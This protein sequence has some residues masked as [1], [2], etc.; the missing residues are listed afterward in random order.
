MTLFVC[1]PTHTYTFMTHFHV[2][3]HTLIHLW[4]I[5]MSSYPYLYN[6]TLFACPP[7]YTYILIP[8]YN[9]LLIHKYVLH[10]THTYFTNTRSYFA[11]A[12]YITYSLFDIYTSYD[13]TRPY[14]VTLRPQHMTSLPLTDAQQVVDVLYAVPCEL[15]S[16]DAYGCYMDHYSTGELPIRIHTVSWHGQ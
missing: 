16:V 9:V 2:I 7:T 8:Y 12:I 3:I 10:L 5:L 13:L 11:H 1:P 6:I 4:L 15:L 14:A